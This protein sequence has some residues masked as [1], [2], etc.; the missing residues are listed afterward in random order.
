MIKDSIVFV[1]LDLGDRWSQLQVLN[2]EGEVVEES[3]LPTR[4]SAL[5]RKFTTT[6]RWR[7]AM[8]VGTHS[9]WVS[10]LVKELGHEVIVADA[11]KLRLI[12]RNPRK[13][14]RIDAE[15][16]ARLDPQL[17][18]PVHHRS[19]ETQADLAL[20]PLLDTLG[21]MTERIRAYDRQIEDL[22]QSRYPETKGLRQVGGV[23]ALTSLAYILSL[24]DPARFRKSRE[25]GPFLGMVPRQNQSG[26]ADPQLRITPGL[27]RQGRQDRRRLLAAPTL[28]CPP[29]TG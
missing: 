1:G 2:Q 17:L 6:G 10:R 11:R 13:N 29:R 18:S 4:E 14:D 26:G 7:V 15:Y 20:E 24:E 25:V 12:Y 5:R 22:C 16:L 19:P 27:A 28:D 3:R 23:G 21:E 9:P 8:E